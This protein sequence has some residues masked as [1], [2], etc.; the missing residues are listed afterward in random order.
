MWGTHTFPCTHVT[1]PG[2]RCLL[3]S[4]C[5]AAGCSRSRCPQPPSARG[6]R[7]SRALLAR[8]EE[9]KLRHA[10]APAARAISLA[11]LGSLL[12]RCKPLSNLMVSK[13]IYNELNT[14]LAASFHTY[15]HT[16]TATS[17]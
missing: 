15:C 3:A 5:P 1:V 4:P 9:V 2:A 14:F 17:T 16:F 12:S 10:N 11:F 8:G 7:A 6:S 13:I